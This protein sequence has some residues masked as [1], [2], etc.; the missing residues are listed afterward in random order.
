MRWSTPPT[1][2]ALARVRARS[3]PVRHHL[4]G[5]HP[6]DS[7]RHIAI[8]PH[9]GLYA[10]PSLCGSAEATREW[11]PDFHRAFL[12]G[13]PSSPAP[14]ESQHRDVRR[15]S[16]PNMAFRLF[17]DRVGTPEHSARS[18]PA[19]A[20]RFRG[21]DWFAS[22]DGLP[23][24][25]PP[26]YGTGSGPPSLRGLLLPG[27]RTDQSPSPLLDI[28]TTVAGSPSVG[29]TCTAGMAA[30]FARSYGEI[31]SHPSQNSPHPVFHSYGAQPG[32]SLQALRSPVL[33][34]SISSASPPFS[35]S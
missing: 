34:F 15:T 1:R 14:G 27:F 10:M 12:P 20:S 8:P 33:H 11:V 18:V 13:T 26:W 19:R 25:P 23:G 35:A 3:V 7:R 16:T 17:D 29:G 9:S 32:T 22:A 6:P 21:F 24:C 28:T 30:S 5:P 31:I 2:G 4:I